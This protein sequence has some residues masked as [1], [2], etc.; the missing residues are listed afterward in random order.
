MRGYKIVLEKALEP[1]LGSLRIDQIG[2]AEVLK[3]DATFAAK[4][5]PSTRRNMQAVLGSVLGFAVETGLLAARPKL[6][7]R[8]K[9]GRTVVKALSP[10][11]VERLIATASPS[12][13]RAFLLA[14]FVGLRAGEIRGL[15]WKDVDLKAGHLVVSESVCR[16][17][18]GTPKSGHQRLVPLVERLKVELASTT[19]RPRD[20]PASLSPRGERWSEFALTDAFRRAC[21]RVGLEGQGWRF[22]DLRHFFVTSLF[23]SGA[24]ATVVQALAG[25]SHLT[26]TQRYAH[27]GAVDLR[28]AMEKL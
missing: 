5:K 7:K 1:V 15:R 14:A 27:V 23:L 17:V 10:D 12:L 8:P 22:H 13:R 4:A 26:T 25:H 16:G 18:V 3:I 24:P 19:E 11:E 6:P 20:A 9:V 2:V 21:T 28:T